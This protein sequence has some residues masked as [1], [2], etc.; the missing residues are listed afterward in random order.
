MDDESRTVSRRTL[1]R[2][3]ASGAAVSTVGTGQVSA[4]DS[5]EVQ[6]R[7]DDHCPDATLEPT[8]GHCVEGGMDG[9]ADEHPATVELRTAVQRSL[10]ERYPDV[11]ALV[12]AGYKPY[13]DTLDRDDDSYAH[14]INPAYIGDDAILDP[15]RP[16]SLLVDGESWRSIGAMFVATRDG[17]RVDP[18][19]VYAEDAHCSPWHYHAGLPGRFAWWYYQQVYEQNAADGDV[20]LPCRTPCMLH[21]W[22][23]DHPESVY[24][25][26]APPVENRD[27]DPADDPDLET[28][29]EPG[30]D[31]LTWETLPDDLVPDRLPDEFAAL[32]P[33]L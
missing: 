31:A 18:P 28:D 13:F 11:A 7:F 8:M 1:L 5:D 23:V 17:E 22:A 29:A 25:H 2:A 30:S 27:L 4:S 16:A 3:S 26:H 14:W 9:C 19:P 6:P 20:R 24:A 10:E 33:G 12:D 15:E 32:I 21:V